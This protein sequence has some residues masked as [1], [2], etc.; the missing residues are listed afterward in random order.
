MEAYILAI[1]WFIS[2]KVHELLKK[3]F[4]WEVIA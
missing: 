2:D 1:I 3:I 4:K